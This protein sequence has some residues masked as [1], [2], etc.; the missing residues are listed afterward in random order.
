MGEYVFLDNARVIIVLAFTATDA[1]NYLKLQNIVAQYKGFKK[2]Y[3]A[4]GISC[5]PA[6]IFDSK[7]R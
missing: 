1:I 7:D 4:I 5:C 2:E 3:K 6:I